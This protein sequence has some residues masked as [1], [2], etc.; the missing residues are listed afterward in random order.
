MSIEVLM[1]RAGQ[2]KATAE[3]AAAVARG[4][5]PQLPPLFEP[6]VTEII[7]YFRALPQLLEDGE[8]GRAVVF[9]G[10][11]IDSIW[12]TFDDA[13]QFGD[14]CFADGSYLIAKIDPD[15]LAVFSPR[16]LAVWESTRS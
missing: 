4:E 7:A 9:R 8:G 3:A 15:N 11:Q 12:D 5:R 6:C 1:H 14:R 13:R 10:E 2:R 16:L